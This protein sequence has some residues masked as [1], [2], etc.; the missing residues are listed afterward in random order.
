M[1]FSEKLKILRMEA[2]MTQNELADKLFIS[3]Q[4]TF[5]A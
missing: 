2:N 4:A 5:T 3:R 1:E